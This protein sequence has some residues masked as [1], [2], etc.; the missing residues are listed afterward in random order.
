MERNGLYGNWQHWRL[1]KLEMSYTGLHYLLRTRLGQVWLRLIG[2][3]VPIADPDTHLRVA[4][5][6]IAGSQHC[7]TGALLLTDISFDINLFDSK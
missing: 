5:A 3:D 7:I 1:I 4:K 6:I 2:P